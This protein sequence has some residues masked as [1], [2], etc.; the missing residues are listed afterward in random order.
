MSLSCDRFYHVCANKLD[1]PPAISMTPP[2]HPSQLYEAFLE[3]VIMFIVLWLFARMRP[4]MMVI[5]GAFLLLYGT[6]RFIVELVRMP[7]THIGYLW[8]DWLTMGQLLS[9]PMIL[10]GLGI[11]SFGYYV[12]KR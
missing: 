9:L 5:S 12:H 10:F 6:F 7:D 4:P 2:L 11:L 8:N 3:G 1:L